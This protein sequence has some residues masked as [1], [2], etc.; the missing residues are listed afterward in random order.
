MIWVD[1][2]SSAG[3]FLDG[4][5]KFKNGDMY[6]WGMSLRTKSKAGFSF[7]SSGFSSSIPN[8]IAE[9]SGGLSPEGIAK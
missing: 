9:K 1:C 8:F 4:E 6:S 2:L 5:F 3:C 7:S